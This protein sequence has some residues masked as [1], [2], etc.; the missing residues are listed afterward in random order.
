MEI[1]TKSVHCLNRQKQRAIPNQIINWL[2]DFGE[3]KPASGNAQE[4][5]F[6]KRSIKEMRSQLGTSLVNLCSKFWS[7]HLIQDHHG[8]IITVYWKN[9]QQ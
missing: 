2:Y 4:L 8:H 9:K 6:S 7:V 5:Y 1:M 3:V